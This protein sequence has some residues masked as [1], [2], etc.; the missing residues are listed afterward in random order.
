MVQWCKL[1]LLYCN[2]FS[3]SS[4]SV[5]N[6]DVQSALAP[7]ECG[8]ETELLGVMFANR[9][10]IDIAGRVVVVRTSKRQ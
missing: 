9:V 3:G 8:Y 10:S 6:L 7:C 2:C 1:C 5:I 4:T